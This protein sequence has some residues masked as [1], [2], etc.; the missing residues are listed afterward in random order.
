L[1]RIKEK[2]NAHTMRFVKNGVTLTALEPRYAG[3]LGACA[4]ALEGRPSERYG[5][6]SAPYVCHSESQACPS[7][8]SEES[9]ALRAERFFACG[10]E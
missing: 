9:Y 4:V 10:S 8:R 3:L 6:H 5:C 7:E 2:L 1:S